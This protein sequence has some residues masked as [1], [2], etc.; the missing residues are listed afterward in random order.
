MESIIDHDLVFE[1]LTE[2]YPIRSYDVDLTNRVKLSTLFGFSQE[3]AYQHAKQLGVGP[4]HLHEDGNMWVLSRVLIRVERYAIWRELLNVS[5]QPTGLN[6]VFALRNF[7][8]RDQSKTLIATASTAWLVVCA[9]SR[10]PQ[11]PSYLQQKMG[12]EMDMDAPLNSLE[13]VPEPEALKNCHTHQVRYSDLDMLRHV[14]N[15]RYI[16]WLCNCFHPDF[17]TEKHIN[18][19][20]INFLHESKFGE[21]ILLAKH[22]DGKQAIIQGVKQSNSLPAFRAKLNWE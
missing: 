12:M 13:K 20:N 22:I 14:N 6:G 16:E 2:Q 3:I 19:L 8:F 7:E 18:Q 15:T 11:R 17:F 5:T 9:K 21:E 1:P 4:M 10:R